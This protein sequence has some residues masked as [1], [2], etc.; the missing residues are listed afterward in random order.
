MK[1]QY[2]LAKLGRSI[3]DTDDCARGGV[4]CYK[5]QIPS[6]GKMEQYTLCDSLRIEGKQ[7]Y[8]NVQENKSDVCEEFGCYKSRPSMLGTSVQRWQMILMA[9]NILK[10]KT[11]KDLE[12]ISE[13][14]LISEGDWQE[15]ERKYEE[16]KWAE[17][18]PEERQ[19]RQNAF[20][21]IIME[22]RKKI[23][24]FKN[25]RYT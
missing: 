7:A 4:C 16:R 9:V 20:E 19:R 6:L 18:P 2:Q 8:C 17:L 10:T 14:P 21:D 11:K 15:R 23:G 3:W 1:V 12:R 25:H 24:N 5:F 22:F 13:I